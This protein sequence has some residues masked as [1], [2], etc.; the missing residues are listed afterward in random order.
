MPSDSHSN[1]T[2]HL[3]GIGRGQ[4]KVSKSQVLGRHRAA[5]VRTNPLEAIS[6]AVASNAGSVGRQAAVIAAASGLV[7]TL[8]VPA[9]NT[10]ATREASAV[11]VEGLNAE[12]V[13]VKA[14]AV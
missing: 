4:T 5:P 2:A 10:T 8:G 13:A 12:R 14:V 3:A 6:K 9:Q 1:P 7:L 11:P